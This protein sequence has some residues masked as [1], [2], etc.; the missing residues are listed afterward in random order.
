LTS[1][2]TGLQEGRNILLIFLLTVVFCGFAVWMVVPAPPVGFYW[3]DTWYLVMAEWFSGRTEHR[4]LV[5]NMLHLRQYPP[6]F[7]LALSVTGNIFANPQNAFIVN[8]LFLVAASAVAMVWFVREKFSAATTAIAAVLVVF[9]PVAL[10]WLPTLFSEH[11]F[12]LL[13]IS[14]LVLAT[15]NREWRGLWLVI[16]VIAALAVATRSAGWALLAGM[17]VH[18]VLGR[19]FLPLSWFA[20]GSIAG[21]LGISFLKAGLPPSLSYLDILSETAD[22][23]DWEYMVHQVSALISGWRSLWGSGV[24]GLIAAV[25]V[26]PGLLIRLKMN[27]PDA[28]FVMAYVGMLIAWPFPDHM[29][30][31]LWPA[32]PAFLVA[33]H[34]SMA[35][36]GKQKIGSMIAGIALALIFVASATDGIGRTLSRLIAPPSGELTELSRMP[37]WTRSDDRKTGLEIL[38]T[39]RQFLD[40]MQQISALTA[41]N[42]CVYSELSALVTAQARRSSLASPWNSLDRVEMMQIHCPYY[43]LIPAALPDTESS[44][45]DRFGTAHEEIFRSMAPYDPDGKQILGVFFRLRPAAAETK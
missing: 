19:Q 41:D 3:D 42:V 35:L 36:F 14:A 15:S 34:A 7:P 5:W 10:F 28:W 1:P 43:Y 44:D 13:T 29:S 8:A 27:R 2:A 37:E 23:L 18:L 45:V 6:L 31:F 21:L 24:G 30:R 26:I 40:D 39:R 12:I 33:G 4:E 32:M 38:Q 20:A 16:G 9:N 25:M 22:R 17:L 11:L